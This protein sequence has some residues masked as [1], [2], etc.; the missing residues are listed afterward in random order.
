MLILLANGVICDQYIEGSGTR[1]VQ[2]CPRE[3]YCAYSTLGQDEDE[4][5]GLEIEQ[6]ES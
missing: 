4:D 1:W 2:A 3:E 5:Y 6:G